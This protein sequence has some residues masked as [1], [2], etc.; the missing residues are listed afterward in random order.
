MV[1]PGVNPH[2]GVLQAFQDNGGVVISE[3]EFAYLNS[4]GI[5]IGITGTN[6]KTTTTTFVL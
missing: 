5:F 1:S 4:E 3:V 6:G 2:I